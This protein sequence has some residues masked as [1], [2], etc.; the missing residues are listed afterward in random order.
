MTSTPRSRASWTLRR[1]SWN[2]KGGSWLNRRAVCMPTSDSQ[3][4]RGL[5]QFTI[6]ESV[7]ASR[8]ELPPFRESGVLA[9]LEGLHRGSLFRI[10]R[11]EQ[12]QVILS[13]VVVVLEREAVLLDLDEPVLRPGSTMDVRP[14]LAD[15]ASLRHPVIEHETSL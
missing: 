15:A 9:F 6:S 13:G 10:A 3:M 1:V 5:T 4:R 8:A 11:I 14:T 12:L 2:R 7:V